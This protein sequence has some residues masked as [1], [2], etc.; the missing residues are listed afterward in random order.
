MKKFPALL[1]FLILLSSLY[2]PVLHSQSF[3][4]TKTVIIIL[5]DE[6]EITGKIISKDSL[7]TTVRSLSGVVSVIPNKQI[8]EIKKHKGGI[9]DG[10]YFKPDPANN[11]LMLMPTGRTLKSGEVQF[12]AVELIFPHVVIGVTDF[13]SVGLGG[14]PFV[15]SGGGTFIYYLSAKVTTINFNEAAVSLGSAMIGSTAGKVVTGVIYAV[16]TFGSQNASVTMGPFFAFSKDEV[17][18]RPAILLGGQTRVSKSATLLTENII[19]FGTEKENFIIFPSIGIRFS[20]EK[21]AADFG[22]YAVI[23]KEGFFYP[24]PWIGLSYKF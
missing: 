8:I 2:T 7:N 14:L 20:G 15:A 21:L 4:S 11:R 9:V 6:T 17:F 13:F 24:I 5:N 22:T 12:N 16:G 1:I 19:I 3:D 10:V 23:E 18:D